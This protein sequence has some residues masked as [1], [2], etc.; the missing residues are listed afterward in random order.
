MPYYNWCI[1]AQSVFISNESRFIV[2][3]HAVL[4]SQGAFPAQKFVHSKLRESLS[5]S[6][7]YHFQVSHLILPLHFPVDNIQ[8]S[9]R[10]LTII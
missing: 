5:V 9:K 8:A 6:Y 3:T 10:K 2:N 1:N 7:T 4:L